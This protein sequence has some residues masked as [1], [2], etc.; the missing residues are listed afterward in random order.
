M[1]IGSGPAGS[2]AAYSLA[3]RGVRTLMVDRAAHPRPKVCG[4]CI[5]PQGQHVLRREG[6]SDVLRGARPLTRLQLHWRGRRVCVRKHGYVSMAR[7]ALDANLAEAAQRAGAHALW[8][9]SASVSEDGSVHLRSRAQEH[10][11]RNAVVVCADGL[12]G[13]SLGRHP[14]FT[15]RV[16]AQSRMGIGATLP[17]NACDLPTDE[18]RMVLVNGGYVGVV[19]LPDGRIDVAA[20]VLPSALRAA[21]G[22]HGWLLAPLLEAGCTRAGVDQAE[23]TGTA[24]LT[25]ARLPIAHG[26]VLVTGDAAAYVEPITGEGISW[27]IST[28]AGAGALAARVV[29]GDADANAWPRL[30]AASTRHSRWR[31]AVMSGLLRVPAL[32]DGAVAVARIA[33][34][35]ASA[36]LR[37]I[38]AGAST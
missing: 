34:R 9:T 18:V 16:A 4:C 8:H 21:G 31:C 12:N 25:R 15:W 24:Q 37:P 10:V 3:R 13:S 32:V 33:P 6:L 5:A 28:G 7:E 1:V 2:M 29:A 11:L 35:T 14:A 17:A 22:P 38:G 20:A 27:A 19:R 26:R 30:H 23:W 36:L